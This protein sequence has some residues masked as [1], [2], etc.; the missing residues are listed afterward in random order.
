M[1]LPFATPPFQPGGGR[2]GRSRIRS[3]TGPSLPRLHFR[4]I[5]R[6]DGHRRVD[7]PSGRLPAWR[8]G[9]RAPPDPSSLDPAL[10]GPTLVAG[11]HGIEP[12]STGMSTT[13]QHRG[14]ALRDGHGGQVGVGAGYIR[15]YGRVTDP[16]AVAADDAAVGLDDGGRVAGWRPSGRRRRRARSRSPSPRARRRW[17][18]RWRARPSSSAP[19]STSSATASMAGWR[20]MPTTCGS[21][22]AG[23]PGPARRTPLRNSTVGSS[24]RRRLQRTCCR[25][26]RI[27]RPGSGRR[28]GPR[29]AP[30]RRRTTPP[31][32][33]PRRARRARTNSAT[34]RSRRRHRPTGDA[35]RAGNAAPSCPR[36]LPR[37]GWRRPGA[38]PPDPPDRCRTQEDGGPVDG[39]LP[40]TT[41]PAPTRKSARRRPVTLTARGALSRS[42]RSTRTSRLTM[43][44]G[45]SRAARG[46][47]RCVETPCPSRAWGQGRMRLKRPRA[48][49]GGQSL[50]TGRRVACALAA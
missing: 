43:R 46:R 34:R 30:R 49:G 6:R 45:R 5:H 42:T 7:F 25:R 2:S 44:F 4:G 27:A 29:P 12:S 35:A 19:A 33:P 39:V 17:R 31:A 23:G 32:R 20:I 9:R 22:R 41:S 8:H 11:P 24:R 40:T 48:P 10:C 37:R 36:R 16:E 38:L 21:R 3:P 13:V 50:H 28:R 47:R 15:H 18:R 1:S 26:Q 14:Q